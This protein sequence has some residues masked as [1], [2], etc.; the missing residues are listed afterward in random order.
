MNGSDAERERFPGNPDVR[1][2]GRRP[3]NSESGSWADRV[4]VLVVHGVA[5][6]VPN[7]EFSNL[8]SVTDLLTFQEDAK[9]LASYRFNQSSTVKFTVGQTKTEVE[10]GYQGGVL[11]PPPKTDAPDAGVQYTSMLVSE[12]A[13][14]PYPFTTRRNELTRVPLSKGVPQIA[15]HVHEFFWADLS[16]PTSW[17][18]LHSISAFLRL[19]YSVCILGSKS[20]PR[21]SVTK[22]GER[23]GYYQMLYLIQVL[24]SWLTRL[25]IP[26]VATAFLSGIVSLYLMTQTPATVDARVPLLASLSLMIGLALWCCA[27]STEKT[28]AKKWQIVFSAWLMVGTVY[29]ITSVAI[30]VVW[31]ALSIG[32]LRYELEEI[33]VVLAFL[34]AGFL[35]LYASHRDIWWSWGLLLAIL[36]LTVIGVHLTTKTFARAV[37]VWTDWFFA[38]Y[39]YGWLMVCALNLLFWLAS[40]LCLLGIKKDF[41]KHAS[42]LWTACIA[43]TVPMVMCMVVHVGLFGA[44]A[45]V[46]RTKEL[47]F[48]PLTL[49]V[50]H[51]GSIF[52]LQDAPV[53]PQVFTNAL[54]RWEAFTEHPA[55][56]YAYVFLIF[57]GVLALCAALPSAT[58]E[59]NPQLRACDNVSGALGGATNQMFDLLRFSGEIVHR[60]V[61]IGIPAVVWSFWL[62]NTSS[63]YQWPLWFWIAVVLSGVVFIS[64]RVYQEFRVGTRSKSP[65]L[66]VIVPS[67]IIIAAC[68]LLPY[69]NL[70]PGDP[71]VYLFILAGFA[72]LFGPILNVGV[73]VTSWLQEYP[74][75]RTPRARI[76]ARLIALIDH[77]KEQR[78]SGVAIIAHSQG[79]MIV[80]E[81]LRYLDWVDKDRYKG[82]PMSLITLGSPLRQL[83]TVR[84]PWLY[85]WAGFTSN[86]AVQDLKAPPQI[87]AW[88]NAYGAGDYIGRNLWHPSNGAFNPAR[89]SKPVTQEEG[90]I[91]REFCLGAMAHV[92]YWDW[93][94][95][96][97]AQELDSLIMTL[98]H[99]PE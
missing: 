15:V 17:N 3:E 7:R 30:A 52:D 66:F 74:R 16:R 54:G 2:G 76:F 91:R 29:T 38:A 70:Q 81:A 95:F 53:L 50:L 97:V 62:F 57:A 49:P 14:E 23:L 37:F 10:F 75:R 43:G 31:S 34:I 72:L 25:Y 11:P 47:R 64:A 68:F 87:V 8:E 61:V 55:I 28:S 58:A 21:E 13:D 67:F 44:L 36:L 98:K 9:L 35:V 19:I 90:E 42:G 78:Y 5:A 33:Y 82:F 1:L 48:E 6:K 45:L 94:N 86:E 85:D 20:L 46:F 80:I 99:T 59:N 39:W 41:L 26:I 83:Y 88:T 79:T 92:H 69:V 93:R 51:G 60:Y 56:G 18:G 27:G 32:V 63:F 12:F 71:S 22:M 73:D 40:S 89:T 4:A 84:F 65:A 24:I 77:L 96:P